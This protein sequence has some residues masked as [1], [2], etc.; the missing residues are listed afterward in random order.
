MKKLFL[1][2]IFAGSLSVSFAQNVGVDIAAP[3]QKLDVAGAI[4]VG[5]TTTGSAG[6]L[7][8]TGTAFQF[9]DGTQWITLNANTD[10]QVLDVIQLNGTDLEISVENDGQ[11]THSIDLSSFLDNTD[12][13]QFDQVSINGS[14]QLLL[15]ISN[16]GQATHVLDLSGYLDN[17]D[18]Q[19]FDV[20]QLVGTNLQLSLQND[21][22]ATHVVDLSS[23]AV[24]TDDQAIDVLSLTGNTMNISLEDDGQAT[25]TLDLS[26]FMDNTDDQQ[27]DVINITSDELRLSLEADGQATHVLDLSPYKD[28]TDEQQF[29]VVQLSGN[30]LQ[31]SLENDGQATHSIDLSGFADNTDD[32]TIDVLSL[33]GNT[34]NIS[35]EDDGQANQTLDLSQFADNTDD[36]AIT[37]FSL[38][39]TDLQLQVEDDAGG[40]QTVDLDPLRRVLVDD[41]GDTKV[42]VEATA[43]EDQIRLSTAGGEAMRINNTQQVGIGLST[44]IQ[45]KLVVNGSNTDTR[46][47]LG[48]RGGNGQSTFANGAQIAFGYDGDDAFQHFIHTRHNS[49]GGS[50]N[51]A[52][53]FYVTDGTQYNTVTSG[54]TH[55]MSLNSGNVGVGTTSPGRKLDILGGGIRVSGL[56]SANQLIISDADGDLVNLSSLV[57]TG[58]GDNLGNH[59]ATGTLNMNNNE[60]DNINHLDMRAANGYGLRFWSSNDYKISMGN[61][62]EYQYGDVQDYSIKMNMNNDA[63]GDRGWTW[64]VN[65]TTPVASISNGG[66]MTLNGSLFFDCVNCGSTSD[67]YPIGGSGWGDMVI[68]GRVVSA[69]A[70]IH[71][72]PPAGSNVV[73]N[74]TYRAAGGGTAGSAGLQVESL[75]GGG[76]RILMAD[77]NGTLYPTTDVPNNDAGYIWNQ[78]GSAQTADFWINGLA[79]V[80]NA[81]RLDN[82]NVIFGSGADVYGNL[83][84]IQNNSTSYQDG[85][86]LN[87]NSSGGASADLRLY[88]N[89]TNER[90]RVKA[91]TGYVGIGTTAPVSM[92]HVMGRT[93][94]HQSGGGGGQNLFTGIETPGSANGRGQLVVSSS[95]SDVVIAS[96]QANNSHGSTLTF[97]SYNPSNA[98]D[99]R[100]FVVNQ[101]N[102]GNRMHYLDFGYANTGGRTNP[103]SNIN[104]TDQVL[105]LDGLNKRVGVR[106]MDPSST[107]DVHG[108]TTLTRDGATECCSGGD[109]TLAIA[110]N[111]STTGNRATISFHNGGVAE[112]TMRLA[113][114]YNIAGLPYSNRRIH[115]FDWQSNNLGLELEGNLFYGNNS[116]RTQTRDNNTLYGNTDGVLSGFYETSSASAGEGY[117]TGSSGWWHLIDSRHSNSGNN[118]AMQIAGSFY[119]Q[120]LWFRKTNGS[121]T[122]G[123][124]ELITTGNVGSYGDNL[125]NHTAT[126]TLNLNNNWMM[127]KP[128][129]TPNHGDLGIG[130][131]GVDR[132]YAIYQEAGGWSHP[133]PDLM[134]RFH[135]GIK[136]SAH[137]DYG[138]V[139]IYANNGESQTAQ[140]NEAGLTMWRDI[141]LQDYNVWDVNNLT[142]NTIYAEDANG[143]G[144]DV[145]NI[146]DRLRVDL[147]TGQDFYVS[148]DDGR[149]TLR[150]QSANHGQI[151]RLQN[152]WY[153]VWAYYHYAVSGY[154]YFSDLAVKENLRPLS[155][156]S[157]L[158]KLLQ[159]KAYT[160]DIKPGTAPYN[161]ENPEKNKNH[162][163]FI[164]Q[165]LQKLFP[166]VVGQI[167]GENLL[168][169]DYGKVTPIL[170]EAMKEQQRQIEALKSG[171]P[172]ASS[173]PSAQSHEDEELSE[174][175]RKLI[176]TTE[177]Q[178]LEIE[179]LKSKLGAQ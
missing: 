107:F 101:G 145:V 56:S 155:S 162:L 135:T 43:D 91:N 118:Y 6:S 37:T 52:I 172:V 136:L 20:V 163:G 111:T 159:L 89:G 72:S 90:I 15:S 149:T 8:W 97:A 105:T 158:D 144:A 61:T 32:Q 71:L 160:Y 115:F 120:R 2:T 177:K 79:N 25:Q 98:A 117:P 80:E 5:S 27:F 41:D 88:A 175:I 166:E 34:L 94:I 68:Q 152:Y 65:G 179:S 113:Q 137:G 124:T 164:A 30:T 74:D 86:Y 18:E 60:I 31:L 178:Q 114:N 128:N 77:N 10:D 127:V 148:N 99:Y 16:D 69:N 112:G 125:G 122:T 28:N 35:L 133:Y 14:N 1:L 142:V 85:M 165:D 146:I 49:S 3:Q 87:Y 42:E 168:T 70:N 167:D 40:L 130:W 19:Q 11:A 64:G 84:V 121:G 103:H 33:S 169:V 153:S 147:P 13:Q 76:N 48:L 174:L 116:S 151:G 83:R 12:V 62:G 63:Q 22:L 46:A 106:T 92:L 154:Y 100:K 170:V 58:M 93:N 55:V 143:T 119:D 47:T 51:N 161:E 75:A 59:T 150:T 73:I 81:Y 36:Q 39:G 156:S 38:S 26:Q 66:H 82:T 138:G 108:Q 131:H 23:L 109:Y 24:D 132:A 123:W 44:G 102:W 110:E 21:G 45:N 96:S 140:F 171:K 17:T 29:D 141:R 176:E 54:S 157:A 7:R 104:A 129:V 78:F 9:H 134:I 50:T 67:P 95:Y 173:V 139:R 53:D 57:G 4:K 126:T